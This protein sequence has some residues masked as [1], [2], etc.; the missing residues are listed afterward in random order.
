M[1][2][3]K[4]IWNPQVKNLWACSGPL[5]PHLEIMQ[6]MWGHQWM[7]S[8][9]I[10]GRMEAKTA[11]SCFIVC[12]LNFLFILLARMLKFRLTTFL[13]QHCMNAFHTAYSVDGTVWDASW[14]SI[15]SGYPSCRNYLLST[16]RSSRLSCQM[17]PIVA[18]LGVVIFRGVLITS[19][20]GL[21][22]RA[23]V[24]WIGQL[25]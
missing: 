20:V 6:M 18:R 13:L 2:A 21:K 11:I 25:V 12:A 10:C 8:P 17:G 22:I 16:F 14:N 3:E 1:K 7:H 15:T 9:L 19:P 24:A 5:R 23:R 4:T